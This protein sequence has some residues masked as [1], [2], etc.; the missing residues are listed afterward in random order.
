MNVDDLLDPLRYENLRD[1][2]AANLEAIG[3][4]VFTERD[5][6]E[7][8]R[9]LDLIAKAYQSVHLP[10]MG[11]PI[12]QSTVCT[13]ITVGTGDSSKTLVTASTN[14]VIEVLGLAARTPA[15]YATGGAQLQIS[16]GGNDNAIMDLS[17]FDIMTATESG[18]FYGLAS[19]Y[20]GDVGTMYVTPQRLYIN[21]G[22]SLIL[23]LRA[24]PDS[25]MD[26][27]VTTRKVS[28]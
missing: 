11:N 9:M 28:Q 4:G 22:D 7:H 24:P 1:Y 10:T 25:S 21:G 26:I 27:S 13:S 18:V 17:D 8:L 14:E 6:L 23:K 16:A 3:G 20:V 5:T 12:P 19:K 15:S 2:T